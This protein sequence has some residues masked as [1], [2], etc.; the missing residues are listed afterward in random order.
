MLHTKI[1]TCSV[2]TKERSKKLR[3]WAQV[4]QG[5]CRGFNRRLQQTERTHK[6]RVDQRNYPI[7]K[8][9]PRKQMP[10]RCSLSEQVSLSEAFFLLTSSS[11]GSASR[12]NRIHNVRALL[13]LQRRFTR[14][15]NASDFNSITTVMETI[16]VTASIHSCSHRARSESSCGWCGTELKQETV[17]HGAHHLAAA[18]V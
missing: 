9:T 14:W 1:T 13:P 17:L 10:S 16:R 3:N 6:Q 2:V 11:T 5:G 8:D 7:Y 12:I 15:K 18:P 4:F